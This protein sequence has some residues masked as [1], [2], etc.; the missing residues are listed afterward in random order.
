MLSYAP[1]CKL[2]CCAGVY[3]L[4]TCSAKQKKSSLA[5]GVEVNMNERGPTSRDCYLSRQSAKITQPLEL[6]YIY[7][8]RSADRASSS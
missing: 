2:L 7:I 3:L 4:N 5:A 1:D 8:Y 6:S